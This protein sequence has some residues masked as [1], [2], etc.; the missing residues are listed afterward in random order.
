VF[1]ISTSNIEIQVPVISC[2][3]NDKNVFF[4][5]HLLVVYLAAILSPFT[6]FFL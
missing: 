1:L 4:Y 3:D 2:L 6:H 5:V